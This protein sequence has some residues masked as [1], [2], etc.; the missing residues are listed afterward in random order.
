MTTVLVHKKA[1]RS[2]LLFS[3]PTVFSYFFVHRM[4]QLQGW[5]K[6]PV[7]LE[8]SSQRRQ[9]QEER[10]KKKENISLSN[11]KYIQTKTTNRIRDGMCHFLHT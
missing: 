7:Q 5:S 10:E 9:Q 3:Q 6:R 4:H 8:Y 11:K 1:K 2:I